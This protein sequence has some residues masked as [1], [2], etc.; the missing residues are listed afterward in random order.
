MRFRLALL[1]LCICALAGA[2]SGVDESAGQVTA[3]TLD[4]DPPAAGQRVRVYVDLYDPTIYPND[5]GSGPR[6]TLQVTGGM[7][8]GQDYNSGLGGWQTQTGASVIVYPHAAMYWTL[9]DEPGTY[10]LTV[11]FDGSTRTKRVE[12]H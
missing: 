8:Q 10:K 9:P 6:V 7:V 12:I 4:P 1:T 3:I 2:C 11:G 5:L